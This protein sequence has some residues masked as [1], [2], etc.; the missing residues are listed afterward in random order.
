[1][2]IPPNF[3]N[4]AL[5]RRFGDACYVSVVTACIS[6]LPPVDKEHVLCNVSIYVARMK[7][8]ITKSVTYKYTSFAT[9]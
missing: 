4:D 5:K 8:C 6:T 3:N 1:M 2:H 9:F 7:I